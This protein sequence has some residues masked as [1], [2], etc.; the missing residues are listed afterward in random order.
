MY[1][2]H[3]GLTAKPFSLVPNPEILFLSKNHANA[4]TYLEYGL[5]ERA[6]FILLTGE[7]GA[8]KTTLVRHL[9]NKMESRIETAV[10][11]NTNFSADQLF[12]RILNEFEI[13]CDTTGKEGHLAQLYQFLIDRYAMGRHVLLIIDEAQNLTDD[14]LED[15]RMLSNLQ[16]DDQILVQIMLVGQPELKERL[17][18]PEFRQ[19]TQRIAVNYHISPLDKE[20]THHYIGYRIEKAGGKTA[21]FSQ[22]AIDTVYEHSEGIPRTINLICDTALVYGFADNLMRIDKA[23]IGKVIKDEICM[24]VSNQKTGGQSSKRVVSKGVAGP[25][26][27]ERIHW[28]EASL[29]ELK[30]QHEDFV[31]EIKNDLLAKY[32]QLLLMEQRRYDQLMG[33]YTQLVQTKVLPNGSDLDEDGDD[34]EDMAE[35]ALRVRSG[36]K[37]AHL[38]EM[39]D[40]QKALDRGKANLSAILEKER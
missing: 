27:M 10:I 14:A 31:Q 20:Q 36:T 37:F 19:L 2:S 24:T 12:R 23:V 6:G 28:L 11:F 29:T 26:I 9:L 4:L 8:G 3:Y 17:K 33:K 30:Q 13:H 5:S 16:T 18:K 34:H 15:I 39:V 40:A 21:L 35:P 32:Q 1:E 38:M 25:G 7:I 22:E